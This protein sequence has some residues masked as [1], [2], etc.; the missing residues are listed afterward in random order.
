MKVILI[1]ANG[2]MGK[3]LQ[4]FLTIKKIEF[5]G[6]DIENRKI[7]NQ[8][9]ADIVIDFSNNL[10]LKDNLEFA[11][12]NNLP[13][14]IGTTNHKKE[15]IKLI[16][17]YKNHIPIF[18]SP[19][20]SLQFSL[21]AS[22]IKY[23][24]ILDCCEFEIKETHHKHKKDKPSG[25]AK[26]LIKKLN[27]INIKPKVTCTREGEVIGEHK[28][29]VKGKNEVLEINHTVLNRDVFCEGTLKAC[30]FL[31]NKKNGLYLM[32]DIFDSM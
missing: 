4:N 25:S 32:E 1:G 26:L 5:V 30:E 28:I 21:M 24:N 22:F 14:V 13:I 20:M 27:N 18:Y 12:N 15:N 7:L 19:N 6:I 11:K 8:T 9:K 29:I 3:S 23:F 10:A 17:Y 2:R 31:I 16:N